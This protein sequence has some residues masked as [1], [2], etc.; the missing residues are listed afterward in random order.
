MWSSFLSIPWSVSWRHLD[1][2]VGCKRLPSRRV[3]TKSGAWPL[4]EHA[5]NVQGV[6]RPFILGACDS[7][8]D[9]PLPPN[10]LAQPPGPPAET[11]TLESRKGGPG[12]LQRVDNHHGPLGM[13]REPVPRVYRLSAS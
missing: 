11:T 9:F 5:V 4:E 2:I 12:R 13:G 10:A 3:R 8:H 7:C 6:N 1:R